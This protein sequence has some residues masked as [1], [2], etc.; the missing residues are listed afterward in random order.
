MQLRTMIALTLV[1]VALPARAEEGF[2]DTLFG[3]SGRGAPPNPFASNYASA[4]P[5]A[6]DIRAERQRRAGRGGRGT[7]AAPLPPGRIP[8]E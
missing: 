7:Q 3:G 1:L 5:T 2:L 6:D 8:G 4:P